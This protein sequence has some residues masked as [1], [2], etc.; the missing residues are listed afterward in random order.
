MHLKFFWTLFK[1]MHCQGS[2]SLRPWISR[3]YCSKKIS[4]REKIFVPIYQCAQL[5]IFGH[6][7]YLCQSI[8]YRFSAAGRP[9]N[10]GSSGNPAMVWFLR[11]LHKYFRRLCSFFGKSAMILGKNSSLRDYGLSRNKSKWLQGTTDELTALL[12]RI[13]SRIVSDLKKS[14]NYVLSKS[15]SP[16]F[17]T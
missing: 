8:L 17:C 16:H 5:H 2:F 10:A 9:N 7:L 12:S 15:H 1:T 11:K 6:H 3:P 4:A 13:F 14:Q